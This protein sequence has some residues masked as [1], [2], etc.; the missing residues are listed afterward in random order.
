MTYCYLDYESRSECD[1]PSRG[2]FAYAEHPTTEAL[3]CY[4]EFTS[5]GRVF[6]T[7][8]AYPGWVPPA[9]VEHHWGIEYMQRLFSDPSLIFVA[10]NAG[11]DEAISTYTLK[12]PKAR[13]FDTVALADYLSLPSGL[14]DLAHLLWGTGKDKAG[15]QLMMQLCK[16]GR[17]GTFREITHQVLTDLTLYN[18]RDV[19]LMRRFM[20]Q[21]FHLWPACEMPVFEVHQRVNLRGIGL[22]VEAVTGLLS[23]VQQ[24]A[25]QAGH[26]VE[27]VTRDL[28]M[29][30]VSMKLAG[31]DLTRIAHLKDWI[32]K[33][34]D[35]RG[36]ID[37]CDEDTMLMLLAQPDE[38]VPS[39][40]KRVVDSRLSV[41]LASV[42]KLQSALNKVSL[43][44]RLRGQYRYCIAEGT[45]VLTDTGWKPIETLIAGKDQVWDGVEWVHFEDLLDNGVRPCICI[46]NVW[47]TP[48]HKVL[49]ATLGWVEAVDLGSR[50]YQVPGTYLENG[51]LWASPFY[52]APPAI[53]L[54]GARPSGLSFADVHAG[55]KTLLGPETS[56][57]GSRISARV[58]EPQSEIAATRTLSKTISCDGRGEIAGTIWSHAALTPHIKATVFTGPKGLKFVPSGFLAAAPFSETFKRSRDGEMFFSRGLTW[59]ALN[60]Q[61][62]TNPAMSGSYR[63]PEMRATRGSASLRDGGVNASVQQNTIGSS[64]PLAAT[65]ASANLLGRESQTLK[66]VNGVQPTREVRVYDLYNAGPRHRFQA[67]RLIVSNCGAHTSRWTAPGVQLQNLP[68]PLPWL[69]EES[70][71]EA[72]RPQANLMTALLDACRVQDINQFLVAANAVDVYAKSKTGGKADV[73]MNDVLRSLIRPMFVPSAGHKLV[74]ADFA[75]IEGRGSA[76]MAGDTKALEAFRANDA[77]PENNPDMYC[78]MAGHIFGRTITKKKDKV[79]RQAGKT[80]ELGCNFGQGANKFGQ[81]NGPDLERAG[82]TAETVVGKWRE[83]HNQ[84]VRYWAELESAM[85]A[86]IAGGRGVHNFPAGPVTYKHISKTEVQ[87]L[88]P[89]GRAMRYHKARL[90]EDTRSIYP[91]RKQITYNNYRK[92]EVKFPTL[93]GGSLLE[94]AD[95]SLCRDLLSGAM[96]QIEQSGPPIVMHCHDEVMTEVPDAYAQEVAEFIGRTMSTTPAWASGFPVKAEPAILTRYGK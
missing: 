54:P 58:A 78:I 70:L 73:A 28:S 90:A 84:V 30:G 46:D 82:V 35:G 19:E 39:V 55:V 49:D 94:N 22:D 52:D 12:L 72:Q 34:L 21:Y 56:P 93:W 7:P 69:E 51:Q 41:S 37:S 8:I 25:G 36:V 89:T 79:E 74:G 20:E 2:A 62:T 17:N 81:M 65:T 57:L 59:I 76:W 29:N 4:I 14:D 61:A 47:M 38:V 71:D 24:L 96:V 92:G 80:A 40:V 60:P 50:P 43:D 42:K 18:I 91:G 33:M 9:G 88:F 5:G 68:R 1:L 16:P 45:P 44:G 10:H 31:T 13:W 15:Y 26:L 27:D 53:D 85:R 64:S 23:I 67:G 63:M 66:S 83:V 11:F 77:D 86:A 32:N 75:Q 48:D 6:W 87:L 3:C 95:Q